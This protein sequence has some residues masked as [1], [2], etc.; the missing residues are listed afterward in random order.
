[1]N[2][3]RNEHTIAGPC[4]VTG[5]GY[6]TGRVVRVVVSPAPVGTGVQL[7]RSDLPLKPACR[8]AV[9]NRSDAEL[10]TIIQSGDAR[11]EMVEHLLAALAAL[12]IDNCFVEIDGEEFPGLDGS[13]QP[14]VEALQRCGLIIQAKSR[15]RLIVQQTIR[16]EAGNRWV[17]A[18]PSPDGLSSYEYRLS[19]DDQTPIAAQTY[20]FQCTPSRF[21]REVAPARTFVT[22]AQA[23]TL[24]R[25]GLASHVTNQELLVFGDAGP[26]D[27]TL[28]FEDECARHKTL[29]LIGDLSLVGVDLIG[30]FVSNRGGHNLNGRMA[31]ELSKLMSAQLTGSQHAAADR[32]A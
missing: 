7:I 26:V 15:Q 10:R 14:Y 1:V 32:A 30:C 25:Q 27:N 17:E 21:A 4:Q 8:V 3:S 28:R 20:C 18:Q 19:F 2:A 6:W 31:R 22:L 12:E 11:F 5:R 9:A 29:D 24:R 13:S 16:V 23:N